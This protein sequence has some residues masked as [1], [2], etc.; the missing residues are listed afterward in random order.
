M[1]YFENARQ[2]VCIILIFIGLTFL[3]ETSNAQAVDGSSTG[4]NA[5][6]PYLIYTLTL[7]EGS[8]HP[9][10]AEFPPPAIC[11]ADTLPVGTPDFPDGFFVMLGI[12]DTGSSSVVLDNDENTIPLSS[13]A[14]LGLCRPGFQR[15]EG[16]FQNGDDTRR[17]A[18]PNIPPQLDVS[19]W[20]FDTLISGAGI[21]REDFD[22]PHAVVPGI[23]VVATSTG[24]SV[25]RALLGAPITNQFVA[26]I[27]FTDNVTRDVVFV[28]E[29]TGAQTTLFAPDDPS[30]PEPLFDADLTPFGET[31]P[32]SFDNATRDRRFFL[33]RFTFSNGSNVVEQ[34]DD[35]SGALTSQVR[36]HF[37]TGSPRTQVT[38]AM[39]S[40]L[41]LPGPGDPC[42]SP[43]CI[44][45]PSGE[46]EFQNCHLID[47]F[48]IPGSNGSYEYR[49]DNPYVCVDE[50]APAFDGPSD[51]LIGMNYFRTTQILVDG[52]GRRLG[53]YQG[54]ETFLF[55]TI[56]TQVDFNIEQGRVNEI[57]ISELNP[58]YPPLT[59][60]EVSV[61]LGNVVF[62]WTVH[63][64]D[65][66]DR[67]AQ[68]VRL[69][70]FERIPGTPDP[71]PLPSFQGRP[72]GEFLHRFPPGN[73]TFPRKEDTPLFTGFILPSWQVVQGAHELITDF[74]TEHDNREWPQRRALARWDH[75]DPQ[76]SFMLWPIEG[77]PLRV[78]IAGLGPSTD[79]LLLF[80]LKRLGRLYL[81]ARPVTVTAQINTETDLDSNN[82][83]LSSLAPD[84]LDQQLD[85]LRDFRDEVLLASDSG[86]K[87]VETYY[88]WSPVVLE[89]YRNSAV[90]SYATARFVEIAAPIA[91]GVMAIQ[92]EIRLDFERSDQLLQS[93]LTE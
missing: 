37:D 58:G 81:V 19:L 40:L 9:N 83:F 51:V 28:D 63:F 2:G 92:Q 8:C 25:R 48:V 27:D 56:E 23:R 59:P 76:G 82:C 65:D 84:G 50:D 13:T 73:N 66:S 22:S 20:S 74:D 36:A 49:I 52:P 21:I 31:T 16:P 30:I 17:S 47:R 6:R 80:E 44:S 55:S 78:S 61:V 85:S 46:G 7:P 90:A 75:P 33:E 43:Q 87:I 67:V 38:R 60:E 68:N 32:S 39:A 5:N 35:I 18:S 89:R 29:F 15:C 3:P 71:G 72:P 70:L 77:V 4:T 11:S 69:W 45:L 91:E 62:Y 14:A 24:V 41:G 10:T 88:S 34:E 93:A 42:T 64:N 79:L 86:K 12:F 54:L 53:L 57:T 1:S 26:H